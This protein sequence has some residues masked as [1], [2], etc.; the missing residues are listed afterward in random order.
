MLQT[1]INYL[2][3]LQC[4]NV[5]S[6]VVVLPDGGATNPQ[7]ERE[8]T[9]CHVEVPDLM[10][11]ELCL[12]SETNLLNQTNLMI[13]KVDNYALCNL[14]VDIE[15]GRAEIPICSEESIGYLKS[16]DSLAVRSLN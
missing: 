12:N 14:N 4:Q 3:F 9:V 5:H 16:D 2:L 7:Y 1:R 8:P 10:E 11:N 15:K 6:V 13:D